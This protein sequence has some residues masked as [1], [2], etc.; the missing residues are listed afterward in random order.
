MLY[1]TKLKY[2]YLVH[3]LVLRHV[4]IAKWIQTWFSRFFTL[5]LVYE[6]KLKWVNKW[7]NKL[8]MKEN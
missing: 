5:K 3:K 1:E 2:C 8:F 7:L 6:R 4:N